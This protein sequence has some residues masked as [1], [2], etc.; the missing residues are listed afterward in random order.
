MFDE[1]LERWDLVA[2]GGPVR[3][4]SS[5]LLP[6]RCGAKPAMLK[7]AR[8]PE[9]Q[10][11]N[12]LMAWWN[13]RG[14]APVLAQEGDALLMERAG[15]P[16][17]LQAMATGGDDD[18]ATRILCRVAARLHSAP[19]LPPC[20][21][22]SL[23]EWFAPLTQHSGRGEPALDASAAAAR[24][25]L[26]DQTE[27]AV[28]HGD[29]HHGNVLDF[30]ELGWLAIDPK[31]LVGERTFD[32][33]NMLRNPTPELALAPGRLAREASIVAGEA[34]VDRT[35]LLQWLLAFSG[36]SAAWAAEDGEDSDL[37]LAV[38]RLVCAE[39]GLQ[40]C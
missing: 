25:L 22:I 34:K 40:N 19:G 6:V 13:G 35:R 38:V 11:G 23:E 5:D 17:S 27:V 39:L 21:I 33:V 31:G 32:L 37:D 18:E 12:R 7:V 1:Y 3:T 30:G 4:M 14:A 15:A 16:L 2:D 36:L 26:L 10:R 20:E 24:A 8:E 9:E 28:L 29:L